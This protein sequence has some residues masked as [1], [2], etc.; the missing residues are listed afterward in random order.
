MKLVVGLG[1]PGRRYAN[2]RH[3]LGFRVVEALA[4]E[5][6]WRFRP[7]P[8]WRWA[9]GTLSGEDLVLAEPLTFMNNSG[10]AV[11]GLLRELK[12]QTER[13]LV[14]YDDLDLPVG[15]IRVR[16]RGS[17]GGHK[18][19]ASIIEAV[20]T[21]EFVRLRLG[22]GSPGR[23]DVVEYVLSEFSRAEEELVGDAVAQAAEAVRCWV[24]DGVEETMNRFN[25]RTGQPQGDTCETV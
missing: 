1:N 20:H 8:W 13:L 11:R 5:E 12:I 15:Q 2:T 9:R 4:D 24:S 16:R 3:N 10:Q 19:L 22:I 18:G 7:A 25:R 14:V 6:R 23:T 17:S 21:R